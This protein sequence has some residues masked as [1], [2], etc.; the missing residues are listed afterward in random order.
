V[1][2]GGLASIRKALADYEH[3][4]NTDRIAHYADVAFHNAIA[5]ATKNPLATLVLKTISDALMERSR[6]MNEVPGV[7][8]EGLREHRRIYLA[9]KEHNP[10]KAR[11]AMRLHMQTVER[12]TQ[13]LQAAEKAEVGNALLHR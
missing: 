9:I 10:D 11:N 12:N 7:L 5:D 2:R 13:L 8:E 3:A 4:V 1:Q 6:H